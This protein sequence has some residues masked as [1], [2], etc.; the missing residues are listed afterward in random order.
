MKRMFRI[1]FAWFPVWATALLM[2]SMIAIYLPVFSGSNQILKNFPIIIVN[3]DQ[4]FATTEG[5]KQLT[6][7]PDQKHSFNWI[8]EH[9][10][11]TAEKMLKNDKA[12]GA[13]I[14]PAN[15]SASLAEVQKGLMNGKSDVKPAK[16]EI[17]INEGGGQMATSVAVQTLHTIVE[18][19]SKGMSEQLKKEMEDRKIKISPSASS[20]LDNP[21]QATSI[22]V[23]GLPADINKGMTPFMLALIASITGLMGAQMIHGY[24]NNINSFLQDRKVGLSES[25]LIFTEIIMGLILSVLVSSGLMVAVM[26]V[27]GSVHTAPIWQIYLFMLLCTMA[28]YFMF[29][30]IGMLLGKWALLAMF[31]IN[32][33]GI[34]SSGGAI[35]L[36]S[37][38]E[39]HRICSAFLPTRYMVEGMKELFYY[40]GNME[41]GLERALI[42]LI[43]CLVVFV[44]ATVGIALSKFMKEKKSAGNEK[45]TDG[46]LSVASDA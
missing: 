40:D 8:Y 28:M 35:P 22:N 44:I 13:L 16:M 37:V 30:L 10:R 36:V 45:A 7:L 3:E 24:L 1:K 32:I 2:L 43:S 20:L 18:T 12:Y 46:Q 5:G 11:A 25:K 31:P 33:M 23:L 9:D 29:K 27:F 19:T 39:F 6:H 4:Q 41:A 38:P 26:G 15:F 21:I 42:V 34:F 14:I 17:L